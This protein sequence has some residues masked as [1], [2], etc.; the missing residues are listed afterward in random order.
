M[1]KHT[2]LI[3]TIIINLVLLLSAMGLITTGP[4][5]IRLIYHVVIEV[6]SIEH[7]E[8][9]EQVYKQYSWAQQSLKDMKAWKNHEREYQDYVI[10]RLKPFSSPTINILDSH[11]RKTTTPESIPNKGNRYLFFG[12]SLM[13]GEGVPDALTIPSIFS[14]ANQVEAVNY[15]VG[16]YEARQCLAYLTNLYVENKISGGKNTIIF[17]NGIPESCNMYTNR[18]T[19]L[20]T[21]IQSQIRMVTKS[22][23]LSV[24]YIFRPLIYLIEKIKRKLINPVTKRQWRS[25]EE[26]KIAAEYV[27]D[28]ILRSWIAGMHMAKEQKDSF[29][30]VFPPHYSIGYPDIDYLKKKFN[31]EQI[32]FI[33]TVYTLLL[34]KVKNYPELNFIDLTDIFD[35]KDSMYLDQWGHYT[36]KGNTVFSNQLSEK[37]N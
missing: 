4:C 2:S 12:S 36:P 35:T 1:N 13:L 19:E 37:L 9:P 18:R 11:V 29:V 25:P 7:Y 5:L 15:G 26:Q 28:V 31:Q 21:P 33:K 27:S 24:G 20:A 34:E 10:W 30:A 3:K 16:G 8:Y 23:T 17:V 32:D 22:P 6:P 14:G